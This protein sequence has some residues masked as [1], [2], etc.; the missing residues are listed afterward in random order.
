MY[1]QSVA[2]ERFEALAELVRHL[3]DKLETPTTS[4]LEVLDLMAHL[5]GLIEAFHAEMHEYFVYCERNAL[6]LPTV[7]LMFR[8]N[9]VL[10][11]CT[12]SML[13]EE[14]RFPGTSPTSVTMHELLGHKKEEKSWN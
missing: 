11:C 7:I 4:R 13:R 5:A 8:I 2:L 9:N 3:H 12:R 6:N 14:L 1:D 10:N